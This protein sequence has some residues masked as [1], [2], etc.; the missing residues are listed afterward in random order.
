MLVARQLM[1]QACAAAA[2]GIPHPQRLVVKRRGINADGLTLFHTLLYD[3]S[4]SL[5]EVFI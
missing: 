3:I 5:Q 2:A 4:I 1:P